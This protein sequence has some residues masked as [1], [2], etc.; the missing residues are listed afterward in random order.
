MCEIHNESQRFRILSQYETRTKQINPTRKKLEQAQNASASCINT[1]KVDEQGHWW[2]ETYYKVYP[3]LPS[4]PSWFSL[5]PGDRWSVVGKVCEAFFQQW[6]E[7]EL[8]HYWLA[9]LCRLDERPSTGVEMT[10][11][12]L[13]VAA[14]YEVERRVGGRVPPSDLVGCKAGATQIAVGSENH[15]STMQARTV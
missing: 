13:S 8:A 4:P 1:W 6:P 10:R 11:L 15:S 12:A 9:P 2:G 7:E 3:A 14:R 5:R